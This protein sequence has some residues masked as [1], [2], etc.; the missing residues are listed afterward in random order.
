MG[1]DPAARTAD[2]IVV[3]AG[4]STRM[5]GVDKLA[6]PID[7]RPLLAWTLDALAMAPVVARLVVVTSSDRVEAI[8]EA[9]WLPAKVV[10]VVAG[11]DRRQGSVAAGLA[12]LDRLDGGRAVRRRSARRSRA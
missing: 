5:G 10:S 11:A 9:P 3:A 1:P 7:G 6:A 8:R 2:A 4:A 12:E